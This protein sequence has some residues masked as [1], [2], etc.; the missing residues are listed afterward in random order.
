MPRRLSKRLSA[1]AK[2]VDQGSYLADIGSDHA[3]LPI[4]LLEQG[5][6]SYAEAVENKTGPF[7]RMKG[8]ITSYGY[9]SRVHCSLSDGLDEL[10]EGADC[11]ALCGIG[12][13]LTCAI[14]ERGRDKL[15][16][17]DTII[18]DPHRDLREV[19]LRVSGLGYH[20][21]DEEMVYEDKVYYTVMKWR[22]GAPNKPYTAAELTLGPVLLKKRSEV[23]LSFLSD[24]RRKI[25][26]LLNKGLSKEARE[27]YMEL[28]RMVTAALKAE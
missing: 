27:H 24:Q 9:S 4:Y 21:E 16:H 11:V 26:A 5:V 22:K 19:R 20:L 12:G 13:L 8:N 3:Q 15:S 25:N 10:D 23:F 1:V 17:V 28:Y 6:I 7:V 18:L 14:L 2:M